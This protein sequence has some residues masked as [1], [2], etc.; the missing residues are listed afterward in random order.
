MFAVERRGTVVPWL[1]KI[2][3]YLGE[4]GLERGKRREDNCLDL[5]EKRT[6]KL[7]LFI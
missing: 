2:K 6:R 4:S 5:P 3:V 7:R 1:K